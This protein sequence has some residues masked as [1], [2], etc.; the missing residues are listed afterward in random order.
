MSASLVSEDNFQNWT[1]VV[2]Q[3]WHLISYFI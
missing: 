1:A 3:H 2:W